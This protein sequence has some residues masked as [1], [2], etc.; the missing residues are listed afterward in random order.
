METDCGGWQIPGIR[1]GDASFENPRNLRL[2]SETRN[3]GSF[4]RIALAQLSQQ[5][6]TIWNTPVKGTLFHGQ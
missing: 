1:V 2:K 5:T 6:E 3:S 4:F